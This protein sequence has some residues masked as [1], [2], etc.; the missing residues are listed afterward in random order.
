MINDEVIYGF[1]MGTK[2]SLRNLVKFLERNLNCIRFYLTRAK[3]EISKVITHEQKC[4]NKFSKVGQHRSNF[5]SIFMNFRA[6]D[7]YLRIN[8]LIN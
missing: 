7:N 4:S 2:C 3:M 8:L 1:S 6:M 5:R